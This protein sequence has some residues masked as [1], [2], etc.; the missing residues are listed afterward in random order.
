MKRHVLGFDIGSNSVGSA[1]IDR[2]TGRVVT[3][4]SVFPAGVE[5]SDEKRGDPKNAKR[6]MCRR[7]RITLARRAERKRLLRLKLIEAGLLPITVAKFG[8]LLEKSDPWELRRKGLDS[9]LTPF[10]FGRALLHLAQRRGALGLNI[11]AGEL[12]DESTDNDEGDEGKVK[13]GIGRVRTQMLGKNA[14]TF[15]EFIAMVRAERVTP[16]TTDDKRPA[17]MRNGPREWRKPVRNRAA[18]YEH[19]ADRMMIRDEF[20]RLWDRQCE[21]G[22]ETAKLL[23]A[24][25]RKALDDESGDMHWRHR[26]LLFGQRR[27]SWDL[28]TLGRCVLHPEDR[29]VPHADMYASRYLVVETV[30]NLKVIERGKEARPLT[31][32]GAREDQG[33]SQRP[34]GNGEGP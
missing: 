29:C 17:G 32:R 7:A 31:P 30:N 19:C 8:A 34:A 9:P 13:Q 16:I 10:E 20:A 24:D 22:G 14:R 21:L 28:G 11:S 25:L 15:G 18:S 3:G 4:I 1:W 23:T 5:E 12:G 33:V 2:E 26:G 27:Q 6:R